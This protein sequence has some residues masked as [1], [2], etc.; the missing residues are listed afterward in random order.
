MSIVSDIFAGGAEGIFRGIKGLI[1]TFK[2]DP[3]IQAQLAAEVAKA[4]METDAKL[5]AAEA[6]VIAAVNATM[7]AEAKSEH[8]MQWAW[9]PTIGFTFAAVLLNNYVLYSYLAQFG[10]VKLVIHDQVWLAFGAVLG[11]AAWVRGRDRKLNG[12]GNGR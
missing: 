7:Q 8:W 5:V 10:V 11:V 4:E 2:A 6:A 1:G 9:R 3:T 12:N